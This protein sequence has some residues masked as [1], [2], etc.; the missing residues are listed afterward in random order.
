MNHKITIEE[1]EN[2]RIERI[3]ASAFENE[4]KRYKKLEFIYDRGNISYR[5]RYFKDTELKSESSHCLIAIAV[6]EYNS[7]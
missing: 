5:V 3:I 2:Y 7:I 1:A 6:M 4:G